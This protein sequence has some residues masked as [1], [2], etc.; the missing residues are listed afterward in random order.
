[1]K[2]KESHSERLTPSIQ[3]QDPGF[4]CEVARHWHPSLSSCSY[5]S[6]CASPGLVCPCVLTQKCET[7]LSLPLLLLPLLLLHDDRSLDRRSS[8][9]RTSSHSSFQFSLLFSLLL[10]GFQESFGFPTQLRSCSFLIYATNPPRATKYIH[11]RARACAHGH[12]FP[13]LQPVPH[14]RRR[15]RHYTT[16]LSEGW[17]LENHPKRRRLRVR[18]MG[19]CS[20]LTRSGAPARARAPAFAREA[21]KQYF[22]ALVRERE[23]GRER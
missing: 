9:Q 20:H 3:I 15:H 13:D 23:R 1:M 12:L 22:S 7:D 17:G 14:C 18:D 5:S 10:T 19:C 2:H 6:C 8:S 4:G 21:A 11:T 16:T